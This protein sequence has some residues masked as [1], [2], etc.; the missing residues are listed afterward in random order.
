MDIP[1]PASHGLPPAPLV[2]ANIPSP[3]GLQLGHVPDGSHPWVPHACGALCHIVQSVV[4]E[5]GCSIA[6]G[7]IRDRGMIVLHA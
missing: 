1:P 2:V 5:V 7:S 4:G 3:E 6:D